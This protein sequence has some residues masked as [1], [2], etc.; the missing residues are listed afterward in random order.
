MKPEVKSESPVISFD[1]IYEDYRAKGIDLYDVKNMLRRADND[2]DPPSVP[3][4]NV[5]HYL[6][7]ITEIIPWQETDS[8]RTK[9]APIADFL[10]TVPS[11]LPDDQLAEARQSLEAQGAL[12]DEMFDHY[13]KIRREQHVSSIEARRIMREILENY[14]YD[15]AKHGK[16]ALIEMKVDR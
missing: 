8:E 14:G 12:T 11:D 1:K 15:D 16:I 4:V 10:L 9:I 3:Y 7:A 6:L 13:V 2:E 5:W